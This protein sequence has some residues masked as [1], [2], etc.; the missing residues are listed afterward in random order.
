[1]PQNSSLNI[2][3]LGWGSL[4]WDPRT[5]P[6]R[7]KWFDDGP[8]LPVEFSRESSDGRI[9]L[10]ICDVDYHVR[11]YWAL[12]DV[13]GLN[14]AKSELAARESIEDKYIETSI[15]YWDKDSGKSHGEARTKIEAWALTMNIDAVVWTNLKAGFKSSRDTMPSSDDVLDHLRNLPY[16]KRR[17]AEEYIRRAPAQ[18]DTKY[19]RLIEREFGWLHAKP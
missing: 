18:I 11:T 10:V 2:A 4:I 1:V 8:L 7:G 19:R 3:C 6:I 14:T 9:T 17:V 15:G 12:L 16:A 13:M 5:L